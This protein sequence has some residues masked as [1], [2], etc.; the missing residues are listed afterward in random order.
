MTMR[1]IGVGSP[2]GDDRAGWHVAAK[3]EAELRRT[4]SPS[5]G[6]DIRACDRPGAALVHLLAGVQHA[7]IVDVALSA[8]SRPGSVRWLSE[9][10]I[11]AR[12]GVSSHGFGVAEALAL[13]HAL[14]DAPSRVSVLAIAAT[15]L[16]G[17]TLSAPVR[18][19][20]P[21]AVREILALIRDHDAHARADPA[22]NG[23]PRK[24]SGPS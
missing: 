11:E 24:S 10:E 1:V 20:V 18:E 9:G 2:F 5:L 8:G 13:A 16:Q 23:H 7:V 22:A 12:R 21:V 4:A 3:L 17:E 14:G 15:R 6:V 19:A